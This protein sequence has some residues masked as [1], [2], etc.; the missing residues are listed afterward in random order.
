MVRHLLAALLVGSLVG[1]SVS[2]PPAAIFSVQALRRPSQLAVVAQA[3]WINDVRVAVA[4]NRYVN[5]NGIWRPK[6]A[7]D[8]SE[9]G[10]YDVEVVLMGNVPALKTGFDPKADLTRVSVIL[11]QDASDF[12]ADDRIWLLQNQPPEA[13]ALR[14]VQTDGRLT[15]SLAVTLTGVGSVTGEKKAIVY[16]FDLPFSAD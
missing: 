12:G 8:D 6:V 9:P 10:R 13:F 2:G 16:Q 15:G 1:C 5:P 11:R 7:A 14:F 4:A 3:L